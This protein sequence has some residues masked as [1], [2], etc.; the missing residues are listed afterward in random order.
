MSAS[1]DLSSCHPLPAWSLS[2]PF[3]HS[4]L[5]TVYCMSD[6]CHF[7]TRIPFFASDNLLPLK[8]CRVPGYPYSTPK[9][10]CPFVKRPEYALSNTRPNMHYRTVSTRKRHPD[11]PGSAPKIRGDPERSGE[12]RRD[13]ERSGEIRGDPGRSREIRFVSYEFMQTLL[14]YR[15]RPHGD[16]A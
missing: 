4:L 8:L 3:R 2:G 13:P 12:I 11:S 14:G 16:L 15:T 9:L 1:L 10:C 7:G 6:T 5:T